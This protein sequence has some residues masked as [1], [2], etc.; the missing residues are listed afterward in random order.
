MLIETERLVLR[1][2]S[3][4]DA[5]D[6]LEYLREPEV[7]CFARMRLGSLDE[8]RREM[9]RREVGDECCLAIALKESGKVVG[10]IGAHPESN[11]PE[12]SDEEADTF[13][14]YWMLNADYQGKGYAY[15]AA[16]AFF[17]YLFR[18]RGARRIYAYTEDYNLSS[19]HLCEKLGMRREG[20]FREFVTFVKNPDGT[21]R[22]ENTVQYAILRKEW[23]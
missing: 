8:A 1:P 22:Y 18:E 21:P 20:L 10:E 23:R 12:G 2:F 15:E 5:E 16:C 4:G 6:V 19:Q 11:D 7:N 13:S 9:R 14:P 3:E 17:D